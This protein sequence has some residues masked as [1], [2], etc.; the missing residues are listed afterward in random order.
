MEL[1]ISY[2]FIISIICI[3][4][5]CSFLLNNY[6]FKDICNYR[7]T[8][9]LLKNPPLI[10][11]LIP[12]RNESRN[13][14]RCLRSL[15]R[16][17]YPNYEI[18]VLD[19]NSTD[20][21]V[22]IVE[23]L[24]E[25]YDN[26][27]LIKGKPLP[28]GWL[29]KSFACHQLSEAAKGEYFLFTDADT[30]HFKNSISSSLA[31]M[32]A[33]D[34]DAISVFARQITVTL[35]ER[36]MVPIANFFLLAFL[37]LVL[38]F[39]SKSPLFSV[40]IGQFILFKKEVYS[41]IGGHESIKKEI[42][43]DISLSKK[44]KECGF[45]FM[46]FDGKNNFYCRMYRSLGEVVRGYSKVLAAVFNYNSVLQAIVTAGVFFMFLLP[47]ILLPLGIILFDFPKILIASLICQVSL[48]LVIKLIQTI[49]F[50]D[51]FIDIFFFPLSIIYL[52][53]ISIHSIVKSKSASGVYWK[54]R[55]YDVRKEDELKLIK[56]NLK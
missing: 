31:A 18:I 45:K 12:A 6:I 56:D 21:T 33:N 28:R 27:R 7:L 25:K 8:K 39:K 38:I 37:P 55:T 5:F 52:I 10:S 47:F 53:L 46:I 2:N 24:E 30:L 54:G 29:G 51:R 44:V 16:Q 15:A 32:L 43:E 34:F 35:H 48:I 9:D 26:L 17:D 49:R 50:K 3:I 20:D 19:D 23:S 4:I 13:I 42:L 41:K 1:L 40:A 22:Q 36:M 11:V 14:R